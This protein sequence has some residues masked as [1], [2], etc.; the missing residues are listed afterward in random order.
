MFPRPL[1][2]RQSSF[3]ICCR[4]PQLHDCSQP[5]ENANLDADK[6]VNMFIKRLQEYSRTEPQV[7]TA[8]INSWLLLVRIHAALKQA[9]LGEGGNHDEVRGRRGRLRCVL[10]ACMAKTHQRPCAALISD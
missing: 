7:A 9:T 3:I 4:A 6:T 8:W 1:L 2:L 10:L 5:I